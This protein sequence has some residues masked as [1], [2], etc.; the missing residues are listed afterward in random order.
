MTLEQ[1]ACGHFAAFSPDGV[2]VH[3]TCSCPSLRQVRDVRRQAQVSVQRCPKCH[4]A[5]AGDGPHATHWRDGRRVDCGGDE[6]AP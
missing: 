5:M 2:P 4:K 3:R 6:V 1:A